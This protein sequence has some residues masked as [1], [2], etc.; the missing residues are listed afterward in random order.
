M[1]NKLTSIHRK[2][3]LIV[4]SDANRLIVLEQMLEDAGYDTTTTWH[5]RR[6]KA[7]LASDDFSLVLLGEHPPEIS[8]ADILETIWSKAP[9]IPCIVMRSAPSSS[10]MEDHSSSAHAAVSKC[11]LN[12][13]IEKI[14]HCLRTGVEA[15][16]DSAA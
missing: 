12:D 16:C 1:G 13:V 14:N 3:I 15:E 11:T 7:L 8:R 5:V 4:D 10:E 2:K 9:A 6:A